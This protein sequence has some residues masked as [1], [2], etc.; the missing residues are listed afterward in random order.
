MLSTEITTHSN[1]LTEGLCTLVQPWPG[2][3][4]LVP[5]HSLEVASSCYGDTANSDNNR[6]RITDVDKYGQ[7]FCDVRAVML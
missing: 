1:S 3:S 2:L 5:G 6:P 4:T 7:C